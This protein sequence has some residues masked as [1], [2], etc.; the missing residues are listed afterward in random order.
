MTLIHRIDDTF[1]VVSPALIAIAVIVWIIAVIAQL[2]RVKTTDP[3]KKAKATRVF[4]IALLS[5]MGIIAV[6]FLITG[7]VKSE[8]QNEV[9]AQLA[10]EIVSVQINGKPLVDSKQLIT[11]IRQLN[12]SPS[13]HHSHPTHSIRVVLQTKDGDLKLNLARDSGDQQE[14]WVFYPQFK[15]TSMNEVGK[16]STSALDGD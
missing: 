11:D 1:S 4:F 12:M 13:Y 14:Y 15:I 2:R 5:F 6:C 9:A 3:L 8:A 7:I 16:I 10:G